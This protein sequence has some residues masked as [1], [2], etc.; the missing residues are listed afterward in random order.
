[1]TIYRVSLIANQFGSTHVNVLHFRN[2]GEFADPLLVLATA[3]NTWILNN[4]LRLHADN[5][6]RWTNIHV[7]EVVNN[8]E[9][10][11][12]PTDLSGTLG[13]S[14]NQTPIVA[15]VIQLKTAQGGRRGRGRFFLS[16][17]DTRA[18]LNGF[19][20]DGP[21]LEGNSVAQALEDF[22][23]NVGN[24]NYKNIPFEWMVASR[25]QGEA[26][27]SFAVTQIKFRPTPGCVRRRNIGVGG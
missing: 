11:D 12:F 3:C 23:V 2:V 1:M 18:K 15:A 24:P 26:G 7:Q 5:S 21:Q 19:W 16:G 25:D 4:P 22:W 20:A 8:G 14:S 10:L 27:T 9:S 6:V 17:W 13:P